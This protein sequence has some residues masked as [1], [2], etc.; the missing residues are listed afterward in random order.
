MR[1]RIVVHAGFHKTGTTSAQQFLRANG[2]LLRPHTALVLPWK[3][4]RGAARLSA[5]YSRFRTA[6]LLDEFAAEL[7]AVLAGVD[8]GARRGLLLS[9]ENLAGRMPGRDGQTGYDAAPELMGRIAQV[10]RQRFGAEADI[11]FCFVTRDAASWMRSLWVHNLRV[12]R[13]T[14]DLDAFCAGLRGLADAGPPLDRI[15][16]A[17]APATLHSTPLAALSGG[18][19]GPARLLLD[20]IGLPAACRRQLAPQPRGNVAPEAAVADALLALNRSGLDA[21]AL[22]RH[23]A[24]LLQPAD[25][26]TDAG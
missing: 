4:R 21:E 26:D 24:A 20:Q 22:A 12:S 11:R 9:D 2:A 13:L 18:A 8:P 25:G 15:G 3:L 5:R 7:D 14:L 10:L 23:K 19:E 1:R 17:I 16:A 6:Q